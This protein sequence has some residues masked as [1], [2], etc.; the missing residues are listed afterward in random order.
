MRLRSLPGPVLLTSSAL[1]LVGLVALAWR[2][3]SLTAGL[4]V[5]GIAG[6]LVLVAACL[7][8]LPAR[9]VARDTKASD[10]T[11]E[12]RARA[13]NSARTTLVQGLVGLTA[14]IGI[15]IAW[16]QLQNDRQ[17]SRTERQQL[18]DQLILTR[19]GQVAER[20]TRAVEQ[21]GADRLELRLGA[22][23]E[24]ERIAKESNDRGAR[25]VVIEVLTAYL[26]E[27]EPVVGKT[28]TTNGPR[29]IFD[30]RLPDVQLVMTVLA[31]RTVFQSDPPLNLTTADLHQ[32]DV[33]NAPLQGAIL[34]GADFS[35]AMLQGANL[36]GARLN[37]AIL[38]TADLT[39]ANL[40]G[41]QLPSANLESVNMQRANLTHANLQYAH[42]Y[43]ASLEHARLEG[44]ELQGADLHEAR[45]QGASLSGAELK[46]ARC[47]SATIWPAG[48]DWKAAGVVFEA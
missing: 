23:Y 1:V 43:S 19:Q 13:V 28:G 24:L 18:E 36:S 42:L 8:V 47:N 30:T 11:S 37:A 35:A 7:F 40:Y 45:L 3:V 38:N 14:L 2:L 25:L 27:Y 22:I 26:R 16:Q 33:R 39:A 9:L 17:Q 20:L 41:A 29:H 34:Q 44:A 15:F 48:F 31:R 12:Q 32:I 5:V 6:F 46:G 10:L 21:L 4:L